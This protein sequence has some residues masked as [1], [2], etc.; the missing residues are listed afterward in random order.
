MV[1]VKDSKKISSLDPKLTP[2]DLVV[3]S[4]LAEE[5]MHGYRIVTELERRDAKDWATI[6]RPQVYYSLTK[7]SKLKFISV[8]GDSAEA[9]GPDRDTFRINAAGKKAMSN[10]LSKTSWAEQRPP[11]P[12]L[13]WMALST[14][15]SAGTSR[16]MIEARR[17]FLL[18]ELAREVETLR[19]FGSSTE[20]SMTAGRLMVSLTVEQFQTELKWLERVLCELPEARE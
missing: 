2:A 19:V 3:L 14:H 17:A 13:T 8:S 16:E 12:F 7:L 15:V 11:P 6:S 4:L 1:L 18:R 20:K 5:P 10:A 9:L